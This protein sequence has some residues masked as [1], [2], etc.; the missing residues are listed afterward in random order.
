[1]P[2]IKEHPIRR[3]YDAGVKVTLSTGNSSFCQYTKRVTVKIIDDPAMFGHDLNI[4]YQSLVDAGHFDVNELAQMNQVAAKAS[5]LPMD[6]K[7]K[8]W[9]FDE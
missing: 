7:R 9:N 4:E 5:F 6:E 1:M 2:S 8:Y 3:L